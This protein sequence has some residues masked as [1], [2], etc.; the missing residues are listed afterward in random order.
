MDL[1]SSL[2]KQ[3]WCGGGNILVGDMC[4]RAPPLQRRLIQRRRGAWKVVLE[5]MQIVIYIDGIW[6]MVDRVLGS[7]YMDGRYGFLL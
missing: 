4:P 2:L 3:G 5:R 7:W 6:K 1:G